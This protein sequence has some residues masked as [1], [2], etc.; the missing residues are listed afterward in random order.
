MAERFFRRFDKE[1]RGQIGREPVMEML[2][3]LGKLVTPLPTSE[4]LVRLYEDVL[5]PDGDKAITQHDF[6][7]LVLRFFC[8]EGQAPA[9][10]RSFLLQ[11][12]ASIQLEASQDRSF[13]LKNEASVQ[14]EASPGIFSVPV[15]RPPQLQQSEQDLRSTAANSLVKPQAPRQ[16]NA[17]PQPDQH[18]QAIRVSTLPPNKVDLGSNPGVRSSLASGQETHT[19][20]KSEYDD[21]KRYS[22]AEVYS[23][24]KVY[25]SPSQS[26][27][28]VLRVERLDQAQKL[29]DSFEPRGSDRMYTRDLGSFI[30]GLN[31]IFG[32]NSDLSPEEI[33]QYANSLDYHATGFIEKNEIREKVIL[34]TLRQIE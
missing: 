31:A 10:D 30:A 6:E 33:R 8:K 2:R 11:D 5:D 17:P 16:A 15:Q 3:L 23:R 9:Q 25:T 22:P 19:L 4:R 12:K 13:L 14:V 7:T 26:P 28:Q 20:Y 21:P 32:I 34:A 29:L 27:A 1:G 24:G 18:L